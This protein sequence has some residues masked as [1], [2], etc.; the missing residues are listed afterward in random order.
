MYI[1]ELVKRL[2]KVAVKLLNALEAD[3]AHHKQYF[4]EQALEELMGSD[5]VNAY[6]NS[7]NENLHD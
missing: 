7:I 5:F 6:E 2:D 4:I 3:G 1:G